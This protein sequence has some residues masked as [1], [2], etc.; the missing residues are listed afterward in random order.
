MDKKLF[1]PYHISNF[2]I[3]LKKQLDHLAIEKGLKLSKLIINILSNSVKKENPHT[4]MVAPNNLRGE[5]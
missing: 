1:K 4:T 5:I 3:S 2:P